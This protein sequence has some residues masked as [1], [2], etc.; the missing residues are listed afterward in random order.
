MTKERYMSMGY[1]EV[2]GG[3]FDTIYKQFDNG[4]M[5]IVQ[6]NEEVQK[7]AIGLVYLTKEQANKLFG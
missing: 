1:K 2:E 7:D 5:Y 4:N 3:E 6:F